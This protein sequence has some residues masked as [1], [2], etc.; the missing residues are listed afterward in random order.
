MTAGSPSFVA[1]RPGNG[2]P[3][4]PVQQF[5][6]R[7]TILPR[8]FRSPSFSGYGR[9]AAAHGTFRRDA[10]LLGGAVAGVGAG[11]I[12]ARIAAG[13]SQAVPTKT[14][15]FKTQRAYWR[16]RTRISSSSA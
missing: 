15:V 12:G 6:G 7:F 1:C 8:H 9:R 16:L 10:A 13:R 2:V 14:P 3:I 5:R 4:E 11:E